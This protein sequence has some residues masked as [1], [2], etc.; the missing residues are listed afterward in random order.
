MPW[1]ICVILVTT[2]SQERDCMWDT[3]FEVDLKLNN[4]ILVKICLFTIKIY[5]WSIDVIDYMN[6]LGKILTII[7]NWVKMDTYYFDFCITCALMCSIDK[8]IE[9]KHIF[10]SENF[11]KK[12]KFYDNY[13]TLENILFTIKHSVKI[14]FNIN[15]LFFVKV[16][17]RKGTYYTLCIFFCN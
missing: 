15:L 7:K 8:L 9:V 12:I 17:C 5:Q 10:Y 11:T 14:L 4:S 3:H 1:A 13:V 6:C 16:S 2:V